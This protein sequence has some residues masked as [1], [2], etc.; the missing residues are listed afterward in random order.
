MK[1]RGARVPNMP[2]TGLRGPRGGGRDDLRK[3]IPVKERDEFAN[4]QF[5]ICKYDSSTPCLRV[6]EDGANTNTILHDRTN[7]TLQLK[8]GSTFKQAAV[9][10]KYLNQHIPRSAFSSR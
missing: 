3:G 5:K 10:A 8:N 7:F 1:S 2:P 9:V 6:L 4:V